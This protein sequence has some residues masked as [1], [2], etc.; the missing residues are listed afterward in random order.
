MLRSASNDSI[1]P[2]AIGGSERDVRRVSLAIR[3]VAIAALALAPGL[4]YV[5]SASAED[6]SGRVTRVAD[7]AKPQNLDDR[8]RISG[9]DAPEKR[10][11][12]VRGAGLVV[13]GTSR[14]GRRRKSVRGAAMGVA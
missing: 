4:F 11:P 1:N 3:W 5:L 7:G 10:Q 2:D 6:L 8:I 12:G 9:I 13:I 14:A